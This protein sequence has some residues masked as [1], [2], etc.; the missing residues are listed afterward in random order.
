MVI[1]RWG[2]VK[3]HAFGRIFLVMGLA[4]AMMAG[5]IGV[6]AS[7]A[8]IVADHLAVAQFDSIPESVFQEIRDNFQFFYG[9]TSHGSQIVTGIGMLASENASLYAS[10]RFMKSAVTWGIRGAWSGKGK[11]GPGWALI[12]RRMW[13]CGPGVAGVRTTRSRASIFT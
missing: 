3:M 8:A 9:H 1:I 6:G 11:P 13:S 4:V 5:V 10:P 7:E 2:L 12:P